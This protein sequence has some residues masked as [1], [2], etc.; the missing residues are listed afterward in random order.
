M[1]SPNRC[2]IALVFVCLPVWAGSIPGISN[3]DQVDR[4]VYR[5]GQPALEGFN[6]LA[7]LGIRTIIDL[8]EAGDRSKAEEGMVVANG[9][10]YINVPMT[11]HT[12][13]TEAEITS[14]LSILEDPTAGP[15]FVHCMRGADRTGAVIAAYHIDHDQWNND[16]ALKDA[17][18]HR[19]SSLQLP[20]QNFIKN[21]KSQPANAGTTA[22]QQAGLSGLDAAPAAANIRN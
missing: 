1:P 2:A 5:G 3:F 16:R 21:F 14:I 11:G 4:Q 8:R 6:Y 17:K 7:K 15:V 19:M 13:P 10:R 9:M 18:A 20:R 12:P 22:P